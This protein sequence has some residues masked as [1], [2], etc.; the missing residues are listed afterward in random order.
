MP[1]TLALAPD[2]I[3]RSILLGAGVV[4]GSSNSIKGTNTMQPLRQR[5]HML[6]RPEYNMQ[7]VCRVKFNGFYPDLKQ[8]NG[9][10]SAFVAMAS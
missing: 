5:I 3:E 8:E 4:E 2:G 1:W 6:A 9:N 10:V 7:G